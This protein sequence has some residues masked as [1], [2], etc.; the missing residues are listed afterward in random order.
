[1]KRI[2]LYSAMKVNTLD[3]ENKEPDCGI[4]YKKKML[5]RYC[6]CRYVE[7]VNLYSAK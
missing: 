4:E 2:G 6:G 3:D 1:M 5:W 7:N